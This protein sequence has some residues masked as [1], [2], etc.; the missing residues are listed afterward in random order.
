[1]V[2]KAKVREFGDREIS[3]SW[4][5]RRVVREEMYREEE[6]RVR[7]LDRRVQAQLLPRQEMEEAAVRR[8]GRHP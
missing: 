1:V 2:C 4:A 7:A 8:H 5:R 3:R 6:R